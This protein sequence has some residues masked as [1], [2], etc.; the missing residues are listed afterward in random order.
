[1]RNDVEGACR[2]PQAFEV[3][4]VPS[5]FP[6]CSLNEDFLRFRVRLQ[7]Y[8]WPLLDTDMD[9]TSSSGPTTRSPKA[10]FNFVTRVGWPID[11]LALISTIE[12]R[13]SLYLAVVTLS[14]TSWRMLTP[15]RAHAVFRIIAFSGS[16]HT[17]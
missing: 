6:T 16:V 11:R 12:H 14:R 13:D 2:L 7:A 10:N 15:T 4:L 9:P 1:V 5:N 8:V 3:V 17:L